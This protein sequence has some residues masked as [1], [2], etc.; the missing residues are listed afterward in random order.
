MMLYKKIQMDKAAKEAA[1]E[2]AAEAKLAKE[3]EEEVVEEILAEVDAGE[4]LEKIQYNDEEPVEE[5][6]KEETDR[7]TSR[8]VTSTEL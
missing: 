2:E 6:D 3:R 4:K 5:A 8:S 1:E 7:T